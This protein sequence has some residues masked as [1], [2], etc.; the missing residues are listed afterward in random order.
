MK[1]ADNISAVGGMMVLEG[2]IL[3]IPLLLLLFYP[4]E[5]SYGYMFAL[6]GVLSITGGCLVCRFHRQK[7]KARSSRIVTFIWLYGFFLAAV[8]FYLYGELTVAQA[9]FESVSGFTTTGLSVLDVSALPRL[10]LFYRSFLQYVGGLGFVMMM[11]IFIQGKNSVDLYQAEGHPDKLMPNIGKTVK[12]IFLMY[13]FFLIVGTVLYTVFGMPVFD[14]LLH[15]MCALSTGGFSN[16]LESIGYYQ[17]PAIELVTVLLMLIGMTNFSL[18]LLLLKGRVR[19]FLRASEIRFLGGLVILSVPVMTI[20]LTQGG[21]TPLTGLRHAF[22]N[23]FSAVSTT[24]YAT[25]S[26]SL[27]PEPAIGVMI[28]LMLVGGGL[29]STAGGIKLGRVV[30]VLKQLWKN[31]C[32]KMKPE[33]TVLLAHYHSGTDKETLSKERCEEASTYTCVYLLIFLAGTLALTTTAGSTLLEGAFEFAS[34]LGTVGLSIGLTNDGTSSAS[35]LV[36]MAGMILGRLEI[37]VLWRALLR[38]EVS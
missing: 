33:R 37:F 10:F 17:S 3:L 35:L 31:I 13:G 27:W 29:G 20:Y 30:I 7:E 28:L 4:A 18:L 22:F 36:M 32:K 12:V 1:R 14:S 8:P 11:L 24:G 25:C 19:A 5:A 21:Y 2:V 15:T 23:A 16:R 6:P 38:R 34:S 9:L 26:Y